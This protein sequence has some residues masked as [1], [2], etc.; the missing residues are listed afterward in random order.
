[1]SSNLICLK[2]CLSILFQIWT[3][4]L[5]AVGRLTGGSPVGRGLCQ[6]R[7]RKP[8]VLGIEPEHCQHSLGDSRILAKTAEAMQAEGAAKREQSKWFRISQATVRR[9]RRPS[10]VWSWLLGQGWVGQREGLAG[11][12]LCFQAAQVARL[13][14]QAQRGFLDIWKRGVMG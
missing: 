8:G 13:L 6:V 2:A 9:R 1:M 14:T 3:L 10:G 12:R 4:T 7:D 5:E 11:P